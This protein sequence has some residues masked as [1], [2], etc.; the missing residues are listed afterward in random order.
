MLFTIEHR[1][2]QTRRLRHIRP[3]H[4]LVRLRLVGRLAAFYL[5]LQHAG[6][7][8]CCALY[9]HLENSGES[10]IVVF[11]KICHAFQQWLL[12][13]SQKKQQELI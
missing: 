10:A 7:S 1:L 11:F 13:Q 6:H 5:W 12:D 4:H 3:G 8:V 2:N 9:S